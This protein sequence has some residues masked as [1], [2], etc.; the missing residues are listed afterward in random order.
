VQV[1]DVRL[2]LYDGSNKSKEAIILLNFELS[3]GKVAQ[4]F[5]EEFELSVDTCDSLR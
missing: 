2:E 4:A 3:T 5:R 1:R